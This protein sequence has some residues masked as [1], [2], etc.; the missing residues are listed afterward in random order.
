MHAKSLTCA[1][2]VQRLQIANIFIHPYY[3]PRNVEAKSKYD[4]GLIS[5]RE[6][7]KFNDFVQ[8]ICLP[9]PLKTQEK[10][11]DSVVAILAGWGHNSTIKESFEYKLINN[12]KCEKNVEIS[13][14]ID[15]MCAETKSKYYNCYAH[16]GE[17]LAR[18]DDTNNQWFLV[19]I[20]TR[21]FECND[22]NDFF[23]PTVFTRVEKYNEWIQSVII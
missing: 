3:D 1:Y 11:D 12:S 19:G 8:P 9:Q 15:E 10:L 16:I 5:L 21:V 18:K 6:K 14:G 4:I 20:S 23:V 22:K 7:V 2:D 13:L 17:G